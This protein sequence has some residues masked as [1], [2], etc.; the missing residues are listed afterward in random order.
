MEIIKMSCKHAAVKDIFEREEGEYSPIYGCN[1][2]NPCFD[3]ELCCSM[4]RGSCIDYSPEQFV[5]GVSKDVS[6]GQS[7]FYARIVYEGSLIK[8]VIGDN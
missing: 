1:L 7:N 5:T 3:E 2:N 8:I 4:S 6:H